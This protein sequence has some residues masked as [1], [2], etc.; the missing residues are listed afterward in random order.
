MNFNEHV[1]GLLKTNLTHLEVWPFSK[2][3]SKKGQNNM[4]SYLTKSL[5]VNFLRNLILG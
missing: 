3:C 1:F 4:L 5:C 2:M